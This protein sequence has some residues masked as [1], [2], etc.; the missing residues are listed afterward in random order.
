MENTESRMKS[1]EQEVEIMR[2][3]EIVRWRWAGQLTRMELYA[4][5]TAGG[6]LIEI[7]GE[8][9]DR[10]PVAWARRYFIIPAPRVN[11]FHW[12]YSL[13][14]FAVYATLVLLEIFGLFSSKITN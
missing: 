1:E 14:R 13:I 9:P 12:R 3:I 10:K 7:I 8:E 4:R 6:E 5:G 2:W 11:H